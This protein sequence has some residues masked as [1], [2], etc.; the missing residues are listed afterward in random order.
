MPVEE[1]IFLKL[2]FSSFIK[3]VHKILRFLD[4]S[5]CAFK[6]NHWLFQTM[7]KHRELQMKTFVINFLNYYSS[8]F[9]QAVQTPTPDQSQTQPPNCTRRR[10]PSQGPGCPLLP[11]LQ[12][13]PHF[14]Q[15]QAEKA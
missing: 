14:F 2:T 13:V 12:F 10:N 11:R 7:Q 15:K 1:T 8:H 6:A 9:R 4:Q 3:D 5:E